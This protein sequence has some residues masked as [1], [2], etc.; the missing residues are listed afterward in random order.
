MP[1]DL[2]VLHV[3]EALEGGTARHLI[4]VV[5]WVPGVEHHVAVPTRRV[6]ALT[7][8]TAVDRLRAGGATVH[9]VE[10]RRSPARPRNAVAVVELR[11]LI[12]RLGVDVV[13]AHSSV[14]GALGRVAGTLARRPRVYTPNGLATAR[15]ALLVERLLGRLTD[16]F[17]AVSESEA[18][19][20]RANHL[21]PDARL[22]VVP[23]GVDPEPPPTGDDLRTT[24]GL[25]PGTPLLGTVARLVHQKA[26]ERFLAVVGAVL[27][28]HPDAHAVLIGDGPLAEPLAG[29]LA[30]LAA[31]GRFHRIAQVPDAAAVVGH[32]DVF[33]LTS[34]FEGAP[35]APM[36]A[37]RAG[38]PVLL[39]DVVGSRDAVVDGVSGFLVPEDDPLAAVPLILAL[40]GD[41]ERRRQIGASGH[42]RVISTFDLAELGTRLL[43]VYRTVSAR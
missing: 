2:V 32:L 17:V 29:E 27:A 36:E 13:H 9:V 3:L 39:T 28:A 21:V 15:A 38:V 35:Y 26:P 23:N 20:V 18:E 8:T 11:R 31:T 16:R 1:D 37:M 19:L 30:T 14:G 22:V 43:A 10:M 41:G 33:L 7:D 40:L 12:R 42:E 5:R 4:D 25:A 24:L 34:R 6:G